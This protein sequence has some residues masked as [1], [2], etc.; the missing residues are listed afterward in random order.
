VSSNAASLTC[1]SDNVQRDPSQPRENIDAR[2]TILLCDFS[3]P[4]VTKLCEERH[5]VLPAIRTTHPNG[6]LHK[7]LGHDPDLPDA[8]SSILQIALKDILTKSKYDSQE[9]ASV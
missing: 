9:F 8:E 7:Y 1:V 5:D 3:G 4:H 2:S 6:L